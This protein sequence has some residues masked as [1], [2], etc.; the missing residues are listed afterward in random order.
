MQTRHPCEC[1]HEL[2]WHEAG[3]ICQKCPDC[4]AFRPTDSRQPAADAEIND[5][6]KLTTSW[7]D[8][9]WDLPIETQRELILAERAE[10]ERVRKGELPQQNPWEQRIE[11]RRRAETLERQALVDIDA[12]RVQKLEPDPTAYLTGKELAKAKCQLLQALGEDKI[13]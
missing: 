1:G 13:E 12:S 7:W 3:L 11:E 10:Q 2:E 5:D 9:A 6:R 4:A 8:S